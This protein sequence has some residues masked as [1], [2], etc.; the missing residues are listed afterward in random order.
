MFRPKNFET[1]LLFVFNNPQI[2]SIHSFF[3]DGDFLAVWLLNDKIVEMK[4]VK[5]WQISVTPKG[6][7]NFLL[8]IPF[9]KV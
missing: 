2:T 9:K 6:K 7:F 1:P 4:L 5:P 3:V 8:E